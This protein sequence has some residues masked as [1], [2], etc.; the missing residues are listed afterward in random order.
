MKVIITITFCYNTLWKSKFKALEKPAKLGE[1][2]SY[3]VVT[4]SCVSQ[5]LVNYTFLFVPDLC[6]L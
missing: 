2:F 3:F 6:I 1:F 5:F 4:L